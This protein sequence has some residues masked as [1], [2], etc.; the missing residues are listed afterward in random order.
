MFITPERNAAA[1]LELVRNARRSD[2]Y[3]QYI[4]DNGTHVDAFAGFGY[5]LQP[6][7]PFVWSALERLERIVEHG[8]APAGAGTARSIATPAEIA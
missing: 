7:L 5:G 6:M 4:V 1:Y 3:W 8:E 2:R